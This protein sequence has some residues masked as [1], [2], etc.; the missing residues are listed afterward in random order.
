MNIIFQHT[1][2]PKYLRMTIA[3]LYYG[4]LELNLQYLQRSVMVNIAIKKTFYPMNPGLI[5]LGTFTKPLLNRLR[6]FCH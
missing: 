2:K 1:G 3:I 4:S 5:F 6:W